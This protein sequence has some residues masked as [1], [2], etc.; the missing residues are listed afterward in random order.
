MGLL[1]VDKQEGSR[2]LMSCCAEGGE[3]AALRFTLRKF[4]RA[5]PGGPGRLGEGAEVARD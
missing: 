4:L 2:E 3:S 1:D 5:P